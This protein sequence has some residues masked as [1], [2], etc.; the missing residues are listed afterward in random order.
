MYHSAL[1]QAI[2]QWGYDKLQ[3]YYNTLT[4]FT[5]NNTPLSPSALGQMHSLPFK[6]VRGEA[7]LLYSAE[8]ASAL[9]DR[10]RE[11]GVQ[12]IEMEEIKGSEAAHYACVTAKHGCVLTL[13]RL[14][15]A[16]FCI[17]FEAPF[18]FMIVSIA[19]C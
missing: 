1:R 3:E 9:V 12:S 4:S 19:L 11:A 10:L 6:I 2:V 8:V 7:D 13:F 15:H 14:V 17:L 18:V 16:L 5:L